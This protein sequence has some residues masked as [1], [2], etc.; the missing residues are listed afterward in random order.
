MTK[1]VEPAFDVSLSDLKDFTV[2]YDKESRLATVVID[3]S[4]LNQLL[5]V[6]SLYTYDNPPKLEPIDPEY[7][8]ADVVRANNRDAE[9]YKWNLRDTINIL[10]GR[11]SVATS[12]D[13]G[14][15]KD[16]EVSRDRKWR[17]FTPEITPKDADEASRESERWL[18]SQTSPLVDLPSIQAKLVRNE[19]LDRTESLSLL[20]AAREGTQAKKDAEERTRKAIAFLQG[21]G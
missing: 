14:K 7:E 20:R 5:T 19:A 13:Y 21:R 17:K 16:E 18:N 11:L 3:A 12:P 8:L 15:S 2:S 9:R 4:V 1:P 10:T 6:A